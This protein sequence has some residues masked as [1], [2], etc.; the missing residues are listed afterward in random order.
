VTVDL[1]FS[2]TATLTD[3]YT[4]SG[5]QIVIPATSPSGSVTVTAVQD[6]LVDPD[7]TVI[8]D[9]SGVTNGTESG[10]QQETITITDDDP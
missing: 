5:T 7:E 9:I 1:A 4:R 6:A 3:D 10:T 2:G 8:V